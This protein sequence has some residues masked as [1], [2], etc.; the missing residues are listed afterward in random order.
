M[1]SNSCFLNEPIVTYIYI[2]TNHFHVI[3]NC[4]FLSIV[5]SVYTL[6]AKQYWFELVNSFMGSC[7]QCLSLNL[8]SPVDGQDEAQPQHPLQVL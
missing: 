4:H 2:H 3:T 5:S 7:M 8:F 1:V 6:T